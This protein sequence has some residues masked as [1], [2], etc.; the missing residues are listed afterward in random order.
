MNRFDIALGK[1]APFIKDDGKVE[2]NLITYTG[3][4]LEYALYRYPNGSIKK[5]RVKSTKTCLTCRYEHHSS[6]GL[7]CKKCV[8]DDLK[9][10]PA[11]AIFREREMI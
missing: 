3:E 9:W 8:G 1:H 5:E 11:R 2:P 7:I 10:E 4:N 6:Y